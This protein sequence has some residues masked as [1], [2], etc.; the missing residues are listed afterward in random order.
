MDEKFIPDDIAEFVTEKIDSVAELEALLLLRGHPDRRWTPRNIS[1]RLYLSD[2]D[3]FETL[4][5][6]ST[7]GLAIYKASGAGWYEY[8]PGLAEIGRMVDRLCEIYPK[9]I[10]AISNLIHTQAKTKPAK[11]KMT[12]ARSRS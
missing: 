9:K 12:E 5:A 1:Q 8:R 7:K 11:K 10:V 4:V 2:T 6:L 3:A